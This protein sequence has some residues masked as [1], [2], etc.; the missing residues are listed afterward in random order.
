VA[1][2]EAALAAVNEPAASAGEDDAGPEGAGTSAT[3]TVIR[4]D[5]PAAAS[6]ADVWLELRDSLAKIADYAP[7]SPSPS[8]SPSSSADAA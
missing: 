6:L 7:P 1:A 3:T 5:H 8:S 4:G 2:G